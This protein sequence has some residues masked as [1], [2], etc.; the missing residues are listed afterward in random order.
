MRRVDCPTRKYDFPI[1]PNGVRC[2]GRIAIL[3]GHRTSIF[4]HYPGNH[5]ISENGQI[6]AASR[7]IEK[8]PRGTP[9]SPIF[10]R[11]LEL[12][13]AALRFTVEIIVTFFAQFFPGAN[14]QLSQRIRIP[15][16]SDVQR[17]SV[18]VPGVRRILL[19]VLMRVE[20][21]PDIIPPPILEPAVPPGIVILRLSTN[22]NHG[23]D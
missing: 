15:D 18:T 22:I 3:D 12:A 11:H 7:R 14:E 13:E 19:I 5:C 17:S 23:V 4:D 6:T 1:C 2:A 20:D 16:P 8:R 10:L 21:G 9:T